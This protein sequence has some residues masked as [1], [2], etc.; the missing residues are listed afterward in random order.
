MSI[1]GAAALAVTA[2]AFAAS[3]AL[4]TPQGAAPDARPPAATVTA[5]AT[6]NA[7]WSSDQYAKVSGYVADVRVDLGDA[8]KKGDL[9]ATIANPELEKELATAQANVAARR[10]LVG[11]ADAAAQQAQAAVEVAARQVDALAATLALAEV[12]LRRQE[13]LF[14]KKAE[15]GQQIDDARA[16][17]SIAKADVEVARSKVASGQADVAAAHANAAVARA[18]VVVAEAEAE[19]ARALLEYL[20]I[21]APFDGVVTRREVNP[22][23]L[24]DAAGAGRAAPLFTCQQVDR[25]RVLCEVPEEDAARIAVGDAADVKVFGLGG[26]VVSGTVT[27]VARA[28]DAKTR[29]MRTE[30]DLSNADGLLRPGM[31]AEA[32]I[33][34]RLAKPA[35]N[36]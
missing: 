16:R 11:A 18:Q 31:Y 25:V 32:R 36:R 20:R 19:H 24:V 12:T 5:L 29:K 21:V 15:T 35:G 14:A 23:D 27:R 26:S 3:A 13:E 6:V 33:T 34:P 22:G 4:P 17:A 7:Y 8:V 1:L 9:L 2:A 10:E 30:I 28:I